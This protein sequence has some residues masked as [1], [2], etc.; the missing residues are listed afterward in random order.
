MPN[1]Q[2]PEPATDEQRVERRRKHR[3]PKA[4][5]DWERI[6]LERVTGR[7]KELTDQQNTANEAVVSGGWE[8]DV[9]RRLERRIRELAVKE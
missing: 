3:D 4:P 9:L 1:R 2:Q 7:V 6:A 5:E 8:D